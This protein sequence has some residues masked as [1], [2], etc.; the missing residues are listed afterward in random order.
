MADEVKFIFKSLMKVPIIILVC[1]L[2]LNILVFAFSY[3]RLMG[4]SYVIMQTAVENNYLPAQELN[5]LNA[6]AAGMVTGFLDNIS[7]VCD[8]NNTNG[9]AY[10]ATSDNIRTQYGTEM[11][12]GITANFH[13]IFPLVHPGNGAASLE[14]NDNG[15]NNINIIYTV[16]GLKYYPDMS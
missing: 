11:T 13:W 5:S 12:V 4:V 2:V 6:Y 1:Y 9:I 10:N 7:V 8:T 3:F 14:Y 15:N 16:P